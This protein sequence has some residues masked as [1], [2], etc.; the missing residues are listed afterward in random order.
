NR[1]SLNGIEL[2]NGGG[3]VIQ[4]NYIGTDVTGTL[5]LGNGTGL[6][7]TS[8]NN[9]IGGTAGGAGNL[10][11]GSLG[12]GIFIS[13]STG[14]LVQGNL[15]GTDVTGIVNLANGANGV[16]LLN[17]S[18]NT[19][20]GPQAGAT[21]VIAFNRHDGV[22]VDGGTGDSIRQNSI[23]GHTNGLG[24]ELVNGGNNQ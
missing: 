14:N 1:F 6:S 10:I 13:N 21:N 2:R 20:G 15:I 23:F 11:S 19:V 17:A 8:S 22:L 16:H 18:G 3:N 9:V 24:I 7:M 12:D 4:A 5:A